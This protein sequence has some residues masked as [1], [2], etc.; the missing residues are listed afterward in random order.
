MKQ[1]FKENQYRKNEA[2]EGFIYCYIILSGFDDLFRRESGAP[3]F[4]KLNQ[5]V[6]LME[7]MSL[8]AG[9]KISPQITKIT[10]L[11]RV[12]INAHLAQPLDER[13]Y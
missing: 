8:Q 5:R 7:W 1:A 6:K 2:F 13:S 9:T 4:L 10:E 12:S 3:N 11:M